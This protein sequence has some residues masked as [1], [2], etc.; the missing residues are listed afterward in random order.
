MDENRSS[1]KSEIA[2]A[3]IIGGVSVFMNGLMLL[4]M[5]AYRSHKAK[6]EAA[7]KAAASSPKEETAATK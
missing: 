3:C 4:G 1:L 2:H 7:K 6:K 5:S